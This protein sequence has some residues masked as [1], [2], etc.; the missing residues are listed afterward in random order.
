MSHDSPDA[1]R[2]ERDEPLSKHT[3]VRVGGP[4]DYFT[5]AKDSAELERAVRWAAA[6][7]RPYLVLGSGSNVVVGDGGFR[8][9]VV[10]SISRG[11]RVLEGD[12]EY[13]IAELESGTFLP[14]AARRLAQ[15]GLAGLEWGVGIPG[16]AGGAVVGNAGAYGGV[17]DE[18]LV[19]ID[20]L[21]SAG[22]AVQIGSAEL[23]FVY[24]SSTIKRGE[25]DVAVV[26]RV[27]HRL[28]RDSPDAIMA[29]VKG[30]LGERKAKQ[31]VEPSVGSTFKNPDGEFAGGIIERCGLKGATVGGAMVSPRHAN[32]I[33]NTG[34]ATACDV[35]D[36]IEH[37][38]TTVREATGVELETEIEFKG[39]W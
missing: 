35:A 15:Q 3:S 32:Y 26:L 39:E 18:T 27:R 21:D 28:R 29:R 20:G 1:P 8:G 13:P 31:P 23:G 9:L 16:T 5:V 22:R 19:E 25:L 11:V 6:E 36:L 24:R 34:A 4:A 10:K 12:A 33:I 2:I 14:T 37:V 30:F 7:G 38:R 17:T